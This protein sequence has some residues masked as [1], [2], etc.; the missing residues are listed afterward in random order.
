MKFDAFWKLI[1]GLALAFALPLIFLIIIPFCSQSQ[2][3]AIPYPEGQEVEGGMVAYP[4][5]AVYR[6][7]SSDFGREVYASEGCAFCHTQ[8]VRPTYAGPDMWRIGWG[9]R[10]EEGLA[11]E[12]RP[13]DYTL[14]E[15]APLGYQRIGQD[16]SN[17]GHRITTRELMH[18]HLFDPISI[19][20]D[21]GMPAY[22]HLYRKS[23]FG[24]GFE[25]TEKAEAL[26]DY[27][28][29]L[30]KDQP[31]PNAGDSEG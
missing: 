13:R 23:T 9:G 18:Q 14:E 11:R 28:L 24:K 27:L 19:D 12:T 22:K 25:P 31:L 26:V 5:K 29:S 6:H 8:V 10:E 2:A 1:G 7:G 21:S 4:D 3:E 30:K 16:L 15:V 17:V 20:S